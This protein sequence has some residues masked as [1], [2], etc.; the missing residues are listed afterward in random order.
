MCDSCEV[1][2]INGVNCHE[3]GCPDSW[4]DNLK[5]CKWCGNDFLP[6]NKYQDVCSTE[7]FQDCYGL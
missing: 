6:S 5:G 4:K 2:N 7:C 3:H 1:L